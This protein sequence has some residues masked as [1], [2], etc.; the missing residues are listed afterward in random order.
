MD[1]VDIK[2]LKCL[3][4]NAREKASAIADK[5]KLSVSAVTE[6]I[7][8][9]EANGIISKYTVIVDQQQIGNDVSAVVE[10]ALSHPRYT[11]D[12][13]AMIE[14]LPSVVSCY[15]VTGDFDYILHVVTSSTAGLDEIFRKLRSFDGV[16]TTK[17]HMILRVTK[18]E[19]T[20]LPT[21]K[22]LKK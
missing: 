19:Y 16:T 15:T 2:I 17:T 9:M 5:I 13:L 20:I 7:R 8:R 1:N 11:A 18:N 6:R 14:S 22:S 12:F 10:V 21:E 3:K 4:E